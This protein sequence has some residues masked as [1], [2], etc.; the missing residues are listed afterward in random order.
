MKAY[1]VYKVY[2][3]KGREIPSFVGK[4]DNEDDA[5]SCCRDNILNPRAWRLD[6]CPVR[7]YYEEIED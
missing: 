2:Y 6:R 4:F 1:L 5:V 7:M 3:K